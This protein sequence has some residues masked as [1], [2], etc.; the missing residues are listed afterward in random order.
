MI[1]AGIDSGSR[2]LKVALVDSRSLA[3]VASAVADQ[4]LAQDTLAREMLSRLLGEIDSTAA[5]ASTVA[6]GYG[7]DSISSADTTVTEITCHARG[8]RSLVPDART[9]I[10]IGGQD[11]KVI[12]LDENGLVRD[13]AMNERCAAGTGR[14]LEVVAARLAVPIR[15]LCDLAS[16]SSSPSEIN[17]TCVVFAETEITGLLA[18]GAR[19]RDIAAGVEASLASRIQAMARRGSVPVVFTGGVA[20]LPGMV[21]ALSK[22]LSC[23]I[24]VAPDPQITGALGAAIVAATSLADS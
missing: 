12:H 5:P 16:Q 8:V 17:S 6:T 4:G 24:S 22:A 10:D 23:D 20:L 9:V 3:L 7:R 13:F 15:E 1:C 14:F 21:A 19:P 18:S 11:S 2:T